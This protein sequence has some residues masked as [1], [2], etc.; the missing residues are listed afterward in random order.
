MII[1]FIDILIKIYISREMDKNHMTKQTTHRRQKSATD[2]AENEEI[3][4]KID[5]MEHQKV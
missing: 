4:A 3:V 1:I 5:G 2:K